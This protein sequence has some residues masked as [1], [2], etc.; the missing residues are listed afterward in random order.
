MS[1]AG[2]TREGSEERIGLLFY[3][4][5]L[6][7]ATCINQ[8]VDGSVEDQCPGLPPSGCHLWSFLIGYLTF[9]H[10]GLLL[11]SQA[12]HSKMR[13]KCK[14][15]FATLIFMLNR[16]KV[17]NLQFTMNA[18]YKVFPPLI[19]YCCHV[20][21]RSNDSKCDHGAICKIWHGWLFSK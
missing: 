9:F 2:R 8:A 5:S 16:T 17:R 10:Q 13:S 19:P 21:I 15:L 4:L 20:E 7:F 14:L 11:H 6:W 12:F 3:I 18:Q 1:G